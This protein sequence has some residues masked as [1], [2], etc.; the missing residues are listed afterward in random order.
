M[1]SSGAK[2][3]WKVQAG[4][5]EAERSPRRRPRRRGR[6]ASW[7]PDR[8][9]ALAGVADG[10]SSTSPGARS[11][12]PPGACTTIVGRT[13]SQPGSSDVGPVTRGR[14]DPGSHRARGLI[15]APGEQRAADREQADERCGAGAHAG[16]DG[17]PSSDG[18]AS[19]GAVPVV[20]VPRVR[21]ERWVDNFAGRHGV[22]LAVVDGGGGFT[23]RPRTGRLR[24]PAAVRCGVRR[25]GRRGCL[26]AAS[27]RRRGDWGVLLVRKGGFAVARLAGSGWSSTRSGSGTCR[28]GPRR[29]ARASSGSPGAGTTRRGRPTRRPPTT[30]RGSSGR[31][32]RARDRGRP[33]GGRGGAGRPAAGG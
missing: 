2:S 3:A 28:A 20:L 32:R 13:G 22:D 16:S 19:V 24:R 21:L 14:V 26:R 8:V 17:R 27:Q 5:R 18:S 10:A 30:P 12:S 29:A 31:A 33:P 23:G 6:S 25:S 15:S 4:L 1:L 7:R 9:G 11:S